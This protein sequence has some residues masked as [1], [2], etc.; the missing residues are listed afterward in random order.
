M[1][2]DYDLYSAW[3]FDEE[4]K[5]KCKAC[6]DDWRKCLDKASLDHK[7]EIEKI[8]G[9]QRCEFDQVQYCYD[10]LGNCDYENYG[11]VSLPY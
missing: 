7:C 9:K 2:G 3:A 1:F 8:E 4:L 6:A 10:I 5:K 11:C